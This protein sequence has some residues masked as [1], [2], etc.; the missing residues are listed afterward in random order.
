MRVRGPRHTVARLCV[1]GPARTRISRPTPPAASNLPARP[2]GRRPIGPPAPPPRRQARD[3]VALV[4]EAQ[5]PLGRRRLQRARAGVA[6]SAARKCVAGHAQ[7]RLRQHRSRG[8]PVGRWLREAGGGQRVAAETCVGKTQ[9]SGAIAVFP[10]RRDV[11]MACHGSTVGGSTL[12]HSSWLATRGGSGSRSLED[13]LLADLRSPHREQQPA[14]KPEQSRPTGYGALMQGAWHCLARR[15]QE[16]GRHTSTLRC[17]PSLPHDIHDVS[18]GL[19]N[20]RACTPSRVTC[21]SGCLG[22]VRHVQHG[23]PSLDARPHTCRLRH[24]RTHTVLNKYT[25]R[26][27]CIHTPHKQTDQTKPN[28][29]TVTQKANQNI[30]KAQR[31][32]TNQNKSQQHKTKQL[33]KHIIKQSKTQQTII[34]RRRNNKLRNTSI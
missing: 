9:V 32:N 8:G 14:R 5:G 4:Q 12:P 22:R 11:V 21:H 17:N 18:R 3:G 15:S 19:R 24:T 29:T 10:H 1:S 20:G 31:N 30:S 2:T 13:W 28:E 25:R 6:R 27:R 23:T 26:H 34:E 16:P 7:A 33:T